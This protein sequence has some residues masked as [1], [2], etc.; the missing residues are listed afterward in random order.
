MS[1]LDVLRS[2]VAVANNVTQPLQATV[3]YRRYVGEDYQGTVTFSPPTSSS[4]I[5]LKAIVER[6]Q[7]NV[8]S[9]TGELITSQASVMFL[10]IAALNAAT[11]GNGIGIYDQ[12]TLPDGTTG[13]ILNTSGFVDA[14]TGHM[15]ATEVYLG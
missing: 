15:I 14:G 7:R 5:S 3:T 12:I 13:P 9:T 1:L 4:P 6:K 2:G 10:D 11:G 8:K